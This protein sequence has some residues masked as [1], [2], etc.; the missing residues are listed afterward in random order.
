MIRY[1]GLYWCGHFAKYAFVSVA[2]VSTFT[3]C[4]SGGDGNGGL[5]RPR[6]FGREEIEVDF[7][8]DVRPLLEIECLQCHNQKDGARNGGLNLETKE[9]AFTTGR[10]APVIRPGNPDGSL[11]IQVLKISPE[12][13]ASMPP[14]PDKVWGERL[15]ILEQWIAD[16]ANWPDGARLLPP[17][18]WADG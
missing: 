17:D 6:W 5:E 2:I 11:L 14:A 3:G 13:A 18:E 10:R 12:H 9:T 4:R 8:R 1:S 16:G 15:E 7:E